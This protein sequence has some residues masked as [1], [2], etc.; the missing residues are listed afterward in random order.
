MKDQAKKK[1]TTHLLCLI[2]RCTMTMRVVTIAHCSNFKLELDVAEGVVGSITLYD[3][4]DLLLLLTNGDSGG[5][6]R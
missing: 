5:G 2:A 4:V 3:V 1:I 6:Q